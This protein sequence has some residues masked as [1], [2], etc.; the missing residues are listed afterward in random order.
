MAPLMQ[1]IRTR[2]IS[3][4]SA[5]KSALY[6]GVV[7]TEWTYEGF[8]HGGFVLALMVDAALQYQF[9]TARKDLLHLSAHFLSTVKTG[10]CQIR[11][12]QLRSGQSFHNTRAEFLQDGKVKITTLLLFGSFSSKESATDHLTLTPAS[13]LARS[14]PIYLHPSQ[15]RA[16]KK[17]PQARFAPRMEWS[18]DPGPYQRNRRAYLS[19]PE[20]TNDTDKPKAANGRIGGGGLEWSAWWDWKDDDVVLN[21]ATLSFFSDTFQRIP[22]LVAW[23]K[24]SGDNVAWS[25][26]T[27]VLNI[28]FKAPVPTGPHVSGHSVGLY[29]DGIFMRDGLHDGRVE[30]WTSPGRIGEASRTPGWREHQVCLAVASQV[31]L[32]T[33]LGGKDRTLKKPKTKL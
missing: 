16:A 4:N 31:T 17:I 12:S 27:L 18:F 30:I 33:P 28:E 20:S 13:P 8:P 7:D 19:P 5:E 26:T 1:A 3:S 11:L 6:E 9:D 14:I 2:N 32:A 22:D 21:A 29:A 10:P 24:E 23:A 15:A 25:Y